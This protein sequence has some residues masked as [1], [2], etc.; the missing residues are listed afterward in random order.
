MFANHLIPLI[1]RT[2][3]QMAQIA[4][5][6]HAGQI[7]RRNGEA[8]FQPEGAPIRSLYRFSAQSE[9]R[10]RGIR[11]ELVRMARLALS[12]SQVD[13][14]VL[15]DGGVRTIEQQRRLVNRGVSQTMNSKHLPQ[16]DGMGWAIDLNAYRGGQ[17]SWDWDD[18][19]L[20]AMAVDRA[21]E[22]M[23]IARNIRWGGAWDRRLSDFGGDARAYAQA[24]ADYSAR[25]RAMGRRRIFIDGP[26]YEYCQ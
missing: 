25:R 7:L 23:G 17:V 6:Y 9:A 20:I 21:A 4:A 26:H 22:E 5:D 1:T 12:Y 8:P 13:M 15:Q 10:M 14:I 19:Y 18:Y 2:G 24:V 3:S 16:A 11:P